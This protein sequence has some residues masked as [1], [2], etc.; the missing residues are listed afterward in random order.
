[1]TSEGQVVAKAPKNTFWNG[2]AY[3]Y[4]LRF[5]LCTCTTCVITLTIKM[6]VIV[7]ITRVD[8]IQESEDCILLA[9]QLDLRQLRT[10]N[11]MLQPCLCSLDFT[12]FTEGSVFSQQVSAEA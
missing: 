3:Q 5:L 1:M 9:P 7:P 4:S 2:Y 11:R 8:L 10:V 6:A 12:V